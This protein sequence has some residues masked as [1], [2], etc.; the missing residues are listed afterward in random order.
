MQGYVPLA[1]VHCRKSAR[2]HMAVPYDACDKPSERAEYNQPDAAIV[3]THLAYYHDGLSQDQVLETI[4]TLKGL[5]DHQG[6]SEYQC[7]PTFVHFG[8]LMHRSLGSHSSFVNFFIFKIP[9]QDQK[10]LG[11]GTF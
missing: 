7:E 1:G 2:T 11:S 6:E 3:L 9:S 4:R 8:K 10:M 5:P